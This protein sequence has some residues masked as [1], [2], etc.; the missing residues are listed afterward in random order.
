M[1][2]P[3]V[4]IV[5]K[6]KGITAIQRSQRGIVALILKDDNPETYKQ[7]LTV[8]SI[9]DIPETLKDFNKEQI[10]LALTGY[11]TSPKKVLVFVQSSEVA[12]YNEILIK[13]ENTR[14]DYLVIP[15]IQESEVDSISSWIK[16]C[17]TLKNKKV[18]A[19]LPNCNADHEGVINFTNTIIKTKSKEFTTAEYCSRIA[20]LI[21][22][23]PM[24]ISCTY[25]PLPEIIEVDEYTKEDMDDKVHAGE[26]FIFFDGD[27]HKISRGINSFI[28]LIQDKNTSF[29]KI[30][31]ID[32]MDMIFDDIFK[33][34]HD[35]YI[36]KYANSYDNKCLLISAITGYF[37]Q[38]E[39]D[40]ILD[41]AKN[42]VFI[43]IPAQ[44][45]Y[46]LSTGQ[47]TQ[48]EL[49][50]MTEQQIKEANTKDKVFLASNIKILD[51]I[52][53]ITLNITI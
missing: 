11:Q 15:E 2:M 10:E 14:F 20:G 13:L 31:L 23:T 3:S 51:A 35:Y 48:D 46:L 38:L 29:Q 19:V 21:A 32:A 39:L 28:T 25:A 9:T 30:K 36:G 40:G 7:P 42:S 18:K 26:L 34:S 27:K 17:R 12:N 22:G 6:E 5:F 52:E 53:E 37:N 1:K 16:S 45:T 41:K 24:T 8:Y 33:T 50:E 43:D 4:T 49:E 44:K 47:F